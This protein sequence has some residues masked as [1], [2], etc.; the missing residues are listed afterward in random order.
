MLTPTEPA[1]K[2]FATRMALFRSRVKTVA[3]RPNSE[4]FAREITSS[5]VLKVL[6]Q[7]MALNRI[8]VRISFYRDC[9][10]EKLTQISPLA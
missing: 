6:M 7:D 9:T 3:Y 2:F 4:S 1:S 8:F 10:A 5:S